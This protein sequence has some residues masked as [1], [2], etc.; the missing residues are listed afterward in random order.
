MLLRELCND[1]GEREQTHKVRD[2]HEAVEGIGDVPDNVYRGDAADDDDDR[3]HCLIELDGLGAE[4]VLRAAAVVE[5]PAE[6]GR[7][8]E[9]DQRNGHKERRELVAEYRCD[10]GGDEL[11]AGLHAE[12]D[13]DA[14]AYC[15]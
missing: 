7:E 10:G 3:E 9:E 4:Q 12:V 1:A 6:D 5:C 14:A 11:G 2:G 15:R 8:R 13:I